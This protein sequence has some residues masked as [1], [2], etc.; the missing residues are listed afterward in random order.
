[1]KYRKNINQT[2]NLEE[3]LQVLEACVRNNIIAKDPNPNNEEKRK[4]NIVV[5]CAK[6]GEK[7]EGWYS[8]N[9]CSVAKELNLDIEGQRV[10]REALLNKGV[11]VVFNKE[12]KAEERA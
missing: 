12:P 3:C 11:E 5:Y 4:N 8:R 1:M 2:L 6:N 10:L 7:P 9:I